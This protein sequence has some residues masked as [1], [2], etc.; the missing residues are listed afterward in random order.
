MSHL[1]FTILAYFL[2]S[3]AVLVDKY[4]LTKKAPNPLFYI[5][6]ISLFSM[7]VLLLFPLTKP[8]PLEVFL[9]G[10]SATLLW[11]GGSYFMF[12]ALIHGNPSRVIPAIGSII[13]LVLA[14]VGYFNGSITPSQAGS[15]VI[16]VG[17][18]ICLTL[19]YMIGKIALTEILYLLI[20]ALFFADSYILLR[21]AYERHDFLSVFVYS[22]TVL[23][24]LL[25]AIPLIPKFRPLILNKQHS[26]HSMKFFSRVGI[27][28]LIGQVFGGLSELLLSYSVSLANPALVNSLQGTQYVFLFIFSIFLS[29]KF[30]NIY[31]EKNS[32]IIL[33]SKISGIAIVAIGLFFLSMSQSNQKSTDYKLGLTFSPRFASQ[34]GLDPLTTYKRALEELNVKYI[35]LPIYWDEFEPQEGKF[36]TDIIIPYLNQAEMHSAKVIL[37][38]GFK[39][40]RWPECYYPPWAAEL[41]KSEMQDKLL[42]VIEKKVV[43]Y[44]AHPALEGWQVENEPFLPFGYCPTEF[45]LDYEFVKKEIALVKKLSDRPILVT[46][47]G[48]ISNWAKAISLT[49]YFGTTLYRQVWNP[50]LG[51]VT[52]PLPPF[53]YQ[54]KESVIKFVTGKHQTEVIISELQ[55]EPWIPGQKSMWEWDVNEQVVAFPPKKITDHLNYAKSTGFKTIYLWGVEWWYFMDHKQHPEYIEEA[56]KNFDLS[57]DNPESI[58]A[59][60]PL[61][62]MR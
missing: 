53:F 19:P 41:S 32:R 39:Q 13:P 49:D 15:V 46:D 37:V 30:P 29:R 33:I 26:N 6:Y 21:W 45:P 2:N 16:L 25:I 9:Y 57:A 47:S 3:V 35:R 40:P 36:N 50:H 1:P 31:K 56:K 51:H 23:I 38:V 61:Y 7:A 12:K 4:L 55:A 8:P 43:A 34:L 11:T 48:E 14:V 54:A 28:F 10:A 42:K 62:Q 44:S 5:Y 59:K 58:S 24:P 22:R 60:Y 20:S 17:G 18:L 52:Y 27:L